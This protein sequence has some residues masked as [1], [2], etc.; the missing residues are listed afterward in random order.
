VV[1]HLR[2]P[3]EKMLGWRMANRRPKRRRRERIRRTT[4][5]MDM[6]AGATASGLSGVPG[7]SERLTAY[8]PL[9]LTA[10]VVALWLDSCSHASGHSSTSAAVR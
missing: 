9:A 1:H 6:T 5:S 8:E 7:P 3:L 4:T 10:T 2:S